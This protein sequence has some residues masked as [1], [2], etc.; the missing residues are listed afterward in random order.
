MIHEV[1][2]D[3]IWNLW[4]LLPTWNYS[5]IQQTFSSTLKCA[6]NI[7][8]EDVKTLKSQY[9]KI[10]SVMEMKKKSISF[11]F[12]FFI[13]IAGIKIAGIKIAGIK[14]AGIKIVT[15]N[16]NSWLE[17]TDQNTMKYS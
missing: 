8:K 12:S 14:I 4:G 13:L 7:L 2:W 1:E 15:V 5:L 3:F 9:F 17:I 16:V 11:S 6:G 10:W